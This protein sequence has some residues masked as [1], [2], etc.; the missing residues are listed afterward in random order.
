[1]KRSQHIP[2]PGLAGV[3][4]GHSIY[5][6]EA[7]WLKSVKALFYSLSREK[8]IEFL[9]ISLLL[10]IEK[11]DASAGTGCYSIYLSK[12]SSPVW[13]SHGR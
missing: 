9:T 4:T 13:R 1:M 8:N 7:V 6:N 10:A 11:K 5:S 12:H 2:I 3:K